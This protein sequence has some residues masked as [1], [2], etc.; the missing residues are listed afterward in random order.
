MIAWNALAVGMMVSTGAQAWDIGW[1]SNTRLPAP[2]PYTTHECVVGGAPIYLPA[3]AESE[4]GL[5]CSFYPG[6]EM[7]TG[8]ILK[9]YVSAVGLSAKAAFSEHQQWEMSVSEV[10]GDW[11]VPAACRDV[12]DR[13]DQPR[14]IFQPRYPYGC[15]QPLGP[16]VWVN[17]RPIGNQASECGESRTCRAVVFGP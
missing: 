5:E 9:N 7:S 16:T 15:P 2:D 8:V 4:Y 1:L 13:G 10:P 11:N 6:E 17:V 12:T 3:C 14:V